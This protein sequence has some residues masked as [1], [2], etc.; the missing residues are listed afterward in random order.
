[1]TKKD[2]LV[3]LPGQITLEEI[4]KGESEGE[5]RNNR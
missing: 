2:I 5:N 4:L 3:I 1:M